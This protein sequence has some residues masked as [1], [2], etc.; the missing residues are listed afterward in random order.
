MDVRLDV[1]NESD[2]KRLYRTDV[3]RRLARRICME[4]GVNEDVRLSVLFCDDD[5]MAK[6][7]RQYRKRSGPTD[8]LAFGQA[9]GTEAYGGSVPKGVPRETY[10]LLGDI[11]ISLETVERD[12]RGNR[13]AM[14][15]HVQLL[16]C[17]GL[18]HLLGFS[19]A[20]A[21]ERAEMTEKQAHYLG[22]S[23]NAAWCSTPHSNRDA[24]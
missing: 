7:N 15:R 9:T 12:S 17:H 6:L 23:N 2:R 11:V 14:R 18:L 19:H 1:R 4:E 16:F 24:E 8:V 10:A 21:R 3:L 13:D 20:R 5:F 22:V